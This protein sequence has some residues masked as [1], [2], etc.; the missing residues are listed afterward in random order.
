MI[1]EL[2]EKIEAILGVLKFFIT[3]FCQNLILLKNAIA[4]FLTKP[5]NIPRFHTCEMKSFT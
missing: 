5:I 1:L 3:E 2:D 4:Q